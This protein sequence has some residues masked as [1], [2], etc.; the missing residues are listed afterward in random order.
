MPYSKC[1][2]TTD[3]KQEG[4]ETKILHNKKLKI[5]IRIEQVNHKPECPCDVSESSI[6]QVSESNMGIIIY[7]MKNLVVPL[8]RFPAHQ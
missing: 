7:L 5:I 3:L 4:T 1:K 8:M 2:T 6:K